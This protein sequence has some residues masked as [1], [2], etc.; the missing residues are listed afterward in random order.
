MQNTTNMIPIHYQPTTSMML[1]LVTTNLI[2]THY[3]YNT[4][5]IPTWYQHDTNT[6]PTWYQHCVLSAPFYTTQSTIELMV[7]THNNCGIFKLFM[8]S[9]YLFFY[10][11]NCPISPAPPVTITVRFTYTLDEWAEYAWPQEPPDPT[12]CLGC[13]VGIKDLHTLPFGA[14]QDPIRY[15]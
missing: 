5:M 14:G 9:C 2:P 12:S 7:G 15:E 1:I 11:K 6:L 10:S 8:T 13:Q 4:N 3:Q